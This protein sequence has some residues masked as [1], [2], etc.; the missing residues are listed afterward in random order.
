MIITEWLRADHKVFR[1]ALREI[2]LSMHDPGPRGAGQIRVALKKLLSRL[3]VH[4]TVEDE[5]LFPSAQR[6]IKGMEPRIIEVFTSGHEELHHK[7]DSLWDALNMGNA[8]LSQFV[9]AAN[10]EALL[11]EHMKEEE[12]ILFP[13]VEQQ[14]P[15]DVQEG[16]AAKAVALAK[17]E[18][19]PPLE[20]QR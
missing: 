17:K 6:Y 14:M 18:E 20:G 2:E 3:K 13:V 11:T 15:K 16:L 4:E 7:I 9:A 5:H 10:F 19:L 8:P 12:E 1:R